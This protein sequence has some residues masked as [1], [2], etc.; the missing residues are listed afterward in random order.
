MRF[1]RR[2]EMEDEA[3]VV[4][5]LRE[6][7]APYTGEVAVLEERRPT[8]ERPLA[9]AAPPTRVRSHQALAYQPRHLAP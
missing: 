2:A 8:P 9:L 3:D 7:L 5:D 4:I 1:G 6:R